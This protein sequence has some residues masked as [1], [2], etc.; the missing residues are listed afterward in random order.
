MRKIIIVGYKSFLQ[1]NLFNYLKKKKL[2]I[3]KV[4][5]SN[6]KKLKI[7][8][9][10]IIINCS[11]TNSFFFKKYRKTNDRNLKI[12]N[13]IKNTK[14]KFIMFST[15]QVYKPKFKIKESSE[16][17][18]VNIYAQNYIKSE[19]NCK[20]LL[21]KNIL[22]L[23]ISNVIGYDIEKKKRLSMLRTMIE[24]VKNKKIYLDNSYNFKKD[25]L[26]V[27]FFCHYLYKILISDVSG[28]L[29]IGSGHSFSLMQI[30]KILIKNR[31]FIKIDLD[32]NKKSND[33]NYSYDVGKLNKITKVKYFRKDVKK[34]IK[35]ICSKFLKHMRI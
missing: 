20:K 35:N 14:A 34:E 21:S 17:K 16:L 11:I 15:R 7:T 33:F 22:I 2:N 3:K 8:R 30:A 18:P 29:N 26:P 1:K 31:N 25:I 19:K 10:D 24:G 32:K 27:N 4:R 5:F 9:E 13:L 12:C 6:I 28:I 23:R